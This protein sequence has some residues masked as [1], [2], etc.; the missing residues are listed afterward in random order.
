M[1]TVRPSIARIFD[2]DIM[3]VDYGFY[4]S[5]ISFT[6]SKKA[7]EAEG[8]AQSHRQSWEWKSRYRMAKDL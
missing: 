3:S 2:N 1:P 7:T 4:V 5:L 8:C 6:R